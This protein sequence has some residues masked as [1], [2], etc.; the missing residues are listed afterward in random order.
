MHGYN[1]W[2]MEQHVDNRYHLGH[3]LG[4]GGMAD[5]YLAHDSI[6]DRSVALKVMSDRYSHDEE[7][8][9]RF[10][11]EAQSAAALSHPNIVSIY[12]RG[13]SDEGSDGVGGT[14]Y[15]AMEYLS[16][17]TLKDRI[18]RRGAIPAGA[19]AG[20]TL[21]IAEAL[22]AAHESGMVHRDIKPHNILI[23]DTGDVKVTD[24]GIARAVTSS[25]MTKTG[26]VLGT[27]HYISPEQAMGDSVGPASDLYSLGVVLYEM[28]TGELPF[29][30][31]TPVGIAM[32]HVN[33]YV[34]PPR[35]ANPEIPDGM[36]AI[37]CRLLAKDPSDRYASADE[38]IEDL[39]RVSGGGEPLEATT[40]V[41][42]RVVVPEEQTVVG[43]PRQNQGPGPAKPEKKNRRRRPLLIA[44]LLLALVG[45]VAG[46]TLLQGPA[47]GQVD[48]LRTPAL[49]GAAENPPNL[50]EVPDLTGMNLD[51]ARSRFGEDF[52]ITEKGRVE[53]TSSVGTILEQS[54]SD[55]REE[56][57]SEISVV[58]SG[59]Q[60]AD[61]PEVVGVSR[62]SAESALSGAGF[63]V[64]V[65]TAESTAAE[66]GLV[67]E[68]SPRAGER[69]ESGSEVGITVGTG[70]SLV[71]VPNLYGTT[72][73]EAEGIL[74]DASLRLGIPVAEPSSDVT[75]GTIFYQN[76]PAGQGVEPGSSVNVSVSTGPPEVPV[77]NVVGLDIA[78]AQQEIASAG[79]EYAPVR[80]SSSEP[81]G[82]VIATDPGAGVPLDPGE[83]VTLSY[84]TGPPPASSSATATSSAS[85][86]PE[87][88]PEPAPQ[89]QPSPDEPTPEPSP[90]PAFQPTPKPAP[91]PTPEPP[92]PAPQPTP[93]PVPQPTPQPGG[94]NSGESGNQG[95]SSGSGWSETESEG[96]GG[97]D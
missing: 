33:S 87:P 86:S 93:E 38:L 65:D 29:D 73:A 57:G 23:T 27:A 72:P 69:A 83:S 17:G 76:L 78:S 2:R 46:Y 44:L 15:I 56:K 6:L 94:G 97:E 35:E 50:V 62:A 89:P 19:A 88:T 54:P 22:G 41:V 80:V 3:M 16:G 42:N 43:S 9:E 84:S 74:A 51:E 91:Q 18:T 67:L 21:Q 53:S 12:D 66:E 55:G 28:L 85:A 1:A 96:E 77:P 90:E 36:N 68:Q 39:R 8:V 71:E 75:E 45:G 14:Y 26:A 32:Q 30:A 4:S 47:D 52:E 31:D 63:E 81:S 13:E 10:K 49:G 70:P 92:E 48:S 82:T 60:V 7:F 11:R 59:M 37:T 64:A 79:L 61:V 58:V 34:R 20:A 25:T 5:V 24:F 40:E 95:G